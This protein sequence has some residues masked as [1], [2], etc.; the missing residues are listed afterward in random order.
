[1]KTAEMAYLL[2]LLVEYA[3][4]ECERVEVFRL[5]LVAD[6]FE[7]QLNGRVFLVL[8]TRNALDVW[9]VIETGLVFPA[10]P[11]A[12]KKSDGSE[13]CILFSFVVLGGDETIV[14]L[15]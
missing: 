14:Q 9:E 2:S 15:Q 6:G 12:A 7:V 8:W 5:R 11:Q 1:M 3:P 10:W 13:G 4:D